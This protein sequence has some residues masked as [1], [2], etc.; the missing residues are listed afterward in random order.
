MGSGYPWRVR[1]PSHSPPS[2]SQ[3]PSSSLTGA[4]P[5]LPTLFLAVL[6]VLAAGAVALLAHLEVSA[7]LAKAD[8]AAAKAR[9]L[10]AGEYLQRAQ[11]ARRA[12][13]LAILGLA[14]LL[15]AVLAAFH[16]RVV[17]RLRYASL[18]G[19]ALVGA[20]LATWPVV[21]LQLPAQLTA[22]GFDPY[23]PAVLAAGGAAAVLAAGRLEPRRLTGLA[24]LL[25]IALWI[26]FDLRWYRSAFA[27]P[28][29]LGLGYATFSLIVTALGLLCFAVV[30]RQAVGARPPRLGDLAPAGVLLLAFG[31]IALPIGLGSGFLAWTPPKHGPLAF[32]AASVGIALTI[33]LPEELFFRGILDHR[34]EESTGRYWRSLLLSSLAFGLM[35]WN[36]RDALDERLLYFFLATIAGVFYGLAYR[37]TR[38]LWAPVLVHTLVDVIWSTFLKG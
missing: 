23:Q 30:G 21:V 27:G 17:A 1:P 33:A 20:A 6:L 11:A 15:A 28:D 29:P 9:E 25:A 13:P 31:V 8:A 10:R 37:K 24:A 38:G 3:L 22:K 26:P 34:L 4:P 18:E 14:P 12:T 16:P 2:H 36:N 35:H 19:L 32:A 5:R 7:L